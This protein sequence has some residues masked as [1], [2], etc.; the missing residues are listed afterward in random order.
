[1]NRNDFIQKI[2]LVGVGLSLTP[3]KLLSAKPSV[4]SFM[5][6]QAAIHIP[7]G[8]FAAAEVEKLMIPEFNLHCTVQQFM[9]NGI[10]ASDD[11]LKVCLFQRNQE[12]VSIAISRNGLVF[13][14][15]KISELNVIVDSFDSP[16]VTISKE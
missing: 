6:P 4:Q 13:H 14:D 10:S 8:N 16:V 1:M 9:R 5:L 15:G 2:G 7:H 12:W 11:D 3:W